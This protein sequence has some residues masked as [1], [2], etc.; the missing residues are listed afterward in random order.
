VII[1]AYYGGAL[2][3]NESD[4]PLFFWPRGQTDRFPWLSGH[5]FKPDKEADRYAV[6]QCTVKK[7]SF[8]YGKYSIC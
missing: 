4:A 8:N 3:F 6:S 2:D 5:C 1:A 7:E